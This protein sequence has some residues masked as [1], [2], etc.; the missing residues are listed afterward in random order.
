MRKIVIRIDD[1][2]PDMNYEKFSDIRD[3][4]IEANI[5]PLIGVVPNNKDETLI[6]ARAESVYKTDDEVWDEIKELHKNHGWEIALHGYEHI[7]KTNDSGIMR[8]NDKS[9]FAGVSFSDQKDSIKQGK[10]ILE[11]KGLSC[12]AFMAPS[13]S[14]DLN[15]LKAVKSIG[16]DII[17]DGKGIYPYELEGCTMMP[18]PYS[19]YWYLP[20][21][22]YTV[23]L[24]PNTMRKKDVDRFKRFINRNLGDIITFSDAEQYYRKHKTKMM[25]IVNTSVD[26]IMLIGVEIAKR[27]STV[28][29]AIK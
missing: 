3:L 18:V 10:R 20:F 29:K 4:L 25:D 11:S 24:H 9:E 14:F 5:R 26:W 19:L 21:G 16:I 2:C 23:C 6:K 13:H 7:K 17:T 27:I 22:I 28:R 12:I 8:I 1:V 15:T